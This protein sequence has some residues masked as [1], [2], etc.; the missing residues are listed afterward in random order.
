MYPVWE[1]RQS[2]NYLLL[3]N[4][5]AGSAYILNWDVNTASLVARNSYQ[6]KP[7][8]KNNRVQVY[9]DLAS[10]GMICTHTHTH[11]HKL[12]NIMHTLNAIP[13]KRIT[14]RKWKVYS[15]DAWQ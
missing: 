1:I 6:G 11:T 8:K 9:R 12:N 13:M 4:E 10:F 14:C 5:C 15:V 2:C 3:R 7:Y